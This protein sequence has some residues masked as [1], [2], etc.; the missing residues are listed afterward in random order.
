M[1]TCPDC[2]GEKVVEWWYGDALRIEECETCHG[3]GEV[4]E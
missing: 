1:K 4:P 2:N 3:T